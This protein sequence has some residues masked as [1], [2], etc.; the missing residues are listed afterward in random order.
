[1]TKEE[2]KQ[3]TLEVLEHSEIAGQI[4]KLQEI[5]KQ[6][7]VQARKSSAELK[8]EQLKHEQYLRQLKEKNG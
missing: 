4:K 1:M 5:Y 2:I 8:I 6:K 3:L 7:E